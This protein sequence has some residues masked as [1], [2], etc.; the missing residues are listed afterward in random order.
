MDAALSAHMILIKYLHH[1]SVG[2]SR[3]A[4]EHDFKYLECA[5]SIHTDTHITDHYFSATISVSNVK[6][7]AVFAFRSLKVVCAI[8]AIELASH[9]TV[10]GV[11][12]LG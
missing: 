9:S 6:L 3:S 7:C 4:V 1:D 12:E 5:L 8:I 11:A 2:C 10:L